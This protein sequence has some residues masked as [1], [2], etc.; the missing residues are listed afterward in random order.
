M[1]LRAEIESWLAWGQMWLLQLVEQL[2][3]FAFVAQLGAIIGTGVAALFLVRLL[4]PIALKLL[5]SAAS[6]RFVLVLSSVVAPI[7]VPGLWLIFLWLIAGAA[8]ASNFPYALMGAGMSL[9]TA[10]VVIK[11]AS[12][13]VQHRL[14]SRVIFVSVF[15]L[16]ALDILGVLGR[17]QMELSRLGFVYGEIRITALNFVQAVIVLAILLW[18]LTLVRSFLE[19]RIL[20]AEALTPSFQ[21]IVIQILKLGFPVLAFLLVLPVL[22]VSLTALTVFG[23]ALAVGVGLGLQGTIANLVAG[24]TLLGSGTIKPGDVVALN[25]V[26]GD[27]IFGRIH[28][29]TMRYVALH[30]RDGTDHIVPNE[31][32]VTNAVENWSHSDNNLR[33]KIPFRISYDANPT[34]AAQLALETAASIKRILPSPSPVCLLKAFGEF[35]LELELRVWIADPMNGVSNVKSEC[36]LGI[37]DRLKASGIAVPVP[38]RDLHVRSLPEGFSAEPGA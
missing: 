20:R 13:V 14:W 26:G 16:A 36:L 22:G 18:L 30:T 32:F 25:D 6:R 27:K 23:G 19:R 34:E 29:I 10:W 21:T 2:Q 37:W 1:D 4:R 7:A 9:L 35:A 31:Y 24:L 5:F 38:Q 15:S 8:R 33:L 11:L 17:V 3:S 28:E 12:Q